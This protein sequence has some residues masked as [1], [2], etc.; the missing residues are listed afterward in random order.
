MHHITHVFE[1]THRVQQVITC[2]SYLTNHVEADSRLLQL[3]ELLN[4]L[5]DQIEPAVLHGAVQVLLQINSVT[6][7]GPGTPITALLTLCLALTRDTE[8]ATLFGEV[9]RLLFAAP[10]PID[11]VS[12]A[13]FSSS[14]DT[15]T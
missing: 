1:L 12:I 6:W 8:H 11:A 7:H 3:I 10:S 15:D 4:E 9:V 5:R 14:G 2:F 13:I